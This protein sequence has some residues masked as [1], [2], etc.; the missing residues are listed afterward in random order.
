MTESQNN[1][2]LVKLLLG[3]ISILFIVILLLLGYRITKF[4]IGPVEMEAPTSQPLTP[5]VHSQLPPS[6]TEPYG[7][8]VQSLGSIIVF[9]NSNAGVQLQIPQSGIYRFAY[10][11]GSYSSYASG[12]EP[13]D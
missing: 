2:L 7:P 11:G 1:S 8:I 12:N 4:T 9:G 13:A 6:T 5:P 3:V 10:R